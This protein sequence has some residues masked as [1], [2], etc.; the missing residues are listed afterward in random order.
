MSYEIKDSQRIH[1]FA[2]ERSEDIAEVRSRAILCR[3]E[4]TGAR[5]LHLSNSDPNNLFCIGFR[6][7][8]FN[9]M[10]VPHILEHSVLAGS[11]KFPLKDPFKEML[12]GSL[13]TF[14]NALTYPDN[15]Q[16][17]QR[18]RR[19]DAE[20]CFWLGKAYWALGDRDRARAAWKD[21]AGQITT[22]DPRLPNISVTKAQDD[23]VRRCAEAVKALDNGRPPWPDDGM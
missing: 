22:R 13:Q 5:L 15:L 20:T 9:N 11:K 21:G 14:L 1:G 6:T 17:G 12:K 10:G 2:V 8:V 23:H 7:P 3:H 4:K 16:V 19:T 18:Y